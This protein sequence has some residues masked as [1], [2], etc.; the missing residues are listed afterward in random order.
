MGARRLAAARRLQTCLHGLEAMISSSSPQ[1]RP[2]AEAQTALLLAAK[3]VATSHHGAAPPLSEALDGTLLISLLM[4]ASAFATFAAPS[5]RA[6]S[7]SAIHSAC[8]RIAAYTSGKGGSSNTSA[9]W[10]APL[11][12]LQR[13]LKQEHMGAAFLELQG[14]HR[15]ASSIHTT[16]SSGHQLNED[17]GELKQRVDS[18]RKR[19]Q[20]AQAC[21]ATLRSQLAALFGTLL[22]LRL[23]LLEVRQ[24]C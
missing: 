9:T 21:V 11:R 7:T 20:D 16:L 24:Y 23:S 5:I 4:L 6:S 14:L 17:A 13:D 12:Q 15:S 3:R 2:K 10:A 18:L 1:Y 22:A 8:K 19:S